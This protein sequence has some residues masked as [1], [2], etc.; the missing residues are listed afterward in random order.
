MLTFLSVS[1]IYQKISD[2]MLTSLHS[3][4]CQSRTSYTCRPNWTFKLCILWDEVISTYSAKEWVHKK[5]QTVF[6]HW[7]HPMHRTKSTGQNKNSIYLPH[8]PTRFY[9]NLRMYDRKYCCVSQFH[10]EIVQITS[11][12][13]VSEI[14]SY[15][16][17]SPFTRS[18][19]MSWHFWTTGSM[20]AVTALRAWDRQGLQGE[21]ESQKQLLQAKVCL[22]PN[23]GWPK[24]EALLL[25]TKPASVVFLQLILY[26]WINASSYFIYQPGPAC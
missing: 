15:F 17:V 12:F 4:L 16:P 19:S 23:F 7:G 13:S 26:H 6:W 2:L 11:L 10:W 20:V 14:L 22:F 18:Y 8:L 3:E 25:P 1:P 5:V 9:R 21:A 24:H